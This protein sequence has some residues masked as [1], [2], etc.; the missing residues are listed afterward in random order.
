MLGEAK[1]LVHSSLPLEL[2]CGG[3]VCNVAIAEQLLDDG[4][5]EDIDI[6]RGKS[7]VAQVDG[8][9]IQGIKA[10]VAVWVIHGKLYQIIFQS[11]VES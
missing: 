1:H 5:S 8:C 2:V 6:G 3:H 9:Y 11:N 7:A 10:L 4:V